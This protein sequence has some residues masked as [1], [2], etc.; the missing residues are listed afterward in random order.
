MDV[1]KKS[2]EIAAVWNSASMRFG[3]YGGVVNSMID[4]WSVTQLTYVGN[5]PSLI[6]AKKEF[7][8]I[9]KKS[10]EHASRFRELKKTAEQ[11]SRKELDITE[12]TEAVKAISADEDALKKRVLEIMRSIYGKDWQPSPVEKHNF[13]L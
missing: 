2:A 8:E 13:G 7:S 1:A 4:Y 11:K 6:A 5:N 12:E 3:N 10:S 9:A